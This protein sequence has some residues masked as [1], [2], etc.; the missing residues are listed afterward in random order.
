MISFVFQPGLLPGSINAA[1]IY[2]LF[3]WFVLL[4]LSWQGTGTNRKDQQL[5]EILWTPAKLLFP[6]PTST[7]T[8][9]FTSGRCT[10]TTSTLHMFVPFREPM[11]STLQTPS[12]VTLFLQFISSGVTPRGCQ[13]SAPNKLSSIHALGPR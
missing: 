8:H 11:S 5:I 13:N 2:S 12:T 9:N 4:T 3:R 1:N 7:N 6:R 10:V